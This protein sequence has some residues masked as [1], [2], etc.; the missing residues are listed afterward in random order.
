MKKMLDRD[1]EQVGVGHGEP[2]QNDAKR[3][4]AQAL[5]DRGLATEG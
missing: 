4:F 1:F 2:I 3:I 5:H